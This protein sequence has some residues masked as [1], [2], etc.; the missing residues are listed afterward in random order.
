MEPYKILYQGGQGEL[1]EKKS[2][3]IAAVSPAGSEQEAAAYYKV[4]PPQSR[5][6]FHKVGRGKKAYCR[7][8]DYD[9]RRS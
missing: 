6:R 9:Y 5:S 1:V 8:R 2:R 3:F 7:K 4:H